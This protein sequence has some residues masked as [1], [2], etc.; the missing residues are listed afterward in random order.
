VDETVALMNC[1]RSPS[2]T[3]LCADQFVAMRECNRPMGPQIVKNEKGVYR[4]L[5][6]SNKEA[7]TDNA[8]QLLAQA[9]PPSD[10][11]TEGLKKAA[12]EYASAMGIAELSDVRF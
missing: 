3:S 2:D 9:N 7:F 11:S 8:S 6:S 1:S 10:R 12:T 4:L 5:D